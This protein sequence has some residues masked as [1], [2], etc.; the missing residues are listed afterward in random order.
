MTEIQKCIFTN[1]PV[2]NLN[3][4]P[5]SFLSIASCCLSHLSRDHQYSEV[6]L[7]RCQRQ[8]NYTL[9]RCER[10]REIPNMPSMVSFS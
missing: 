7:M 2:F 6:N 1:I 5:Y 10:E 4:S 8:R 9:A 3:K